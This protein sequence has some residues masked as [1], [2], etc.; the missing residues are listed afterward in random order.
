[1]LSQVQTGPD[2]VRSNCV[3]KKSDR[4]N[5]HCSLYLAL[6][7]LSLFW[8]VSRFLR[9]RGSPRQRAFGSAF[10]LYSIL[11]LLYQN[12]GAWLQSE[13]KKPKTKSTNLTAHC[14]TVS[15]LV[16]RCCKSKDNLN[17]Q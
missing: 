5:T 7:L 3:R 6:V 15:K 12:N 16:T 4:E 9:T 2:G 14:R 10:Y 13:K 1:M 8:F 11:C 17:Q